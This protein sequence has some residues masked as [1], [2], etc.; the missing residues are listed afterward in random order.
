MALKK[1]NPTNLVDDLNNWHS[2]FLEFLSPDQANNHLQSLLH[3]YLQSPDANN[4]QDR[5]HK[6][7]LYNQ[8]NQ[9]LTL[10]NH[11]S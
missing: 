6:L 9:L 1:I 11:H 10:L 5:N 8:L 2:N 4:Y 7:F 3:V